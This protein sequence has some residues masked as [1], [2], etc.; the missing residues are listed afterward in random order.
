MKPEFLRNIKLGTSNENGSAMDKTQQW[1]QNK[2]WDEHF[3][4]QGGVRFIKTMGKPWEN[5]DL[6]GKTMVIL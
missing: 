5:G 2:N 6:H 3:L 1:L 4:C